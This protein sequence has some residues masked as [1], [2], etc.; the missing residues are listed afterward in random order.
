MFTF[1][2]S[3]SIRVFIAAAC[4][5]SLTAACSSSSSSEDFEIVE[6]L[7]QQVEELQQQLE[8][9][10]ES[11]VESTMSTTTA[12]ATTTTTPATTTTAP[13][14]TTTTTAPPT[15]TTAAPVESIL[16]CE[17]NIMP[18][19]VPSLCGF[20]R[21][22][23]YQDSLLGLIEILGAPSQIGWFSPTCR[24]GYEPETLEGSVRWGN[25][26]V[27]YL[28]EPDLD[29]DW[30]V[31]QEPYLA[32]WTINFMSLPSWMEEKLITP[33]MISLPGGA[34]VEGSI[35]SLAEAFSF[36]LADANEAPYQTGELDAEEYW[37]DVGEYLEE[38][39][40]PEGFDGPQFG[41]QTGFVLH[42]HAHY[43]DVTR[44]IGV[45][46]LPYCH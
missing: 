12:P 8:L 44:A 15:T 14:A 26:R 23:S 2:E 9:A 29:F 40:Y 46:W 13:P 31:Y 22:D 28:Q 33:D 11:P 32:N 24:G 25:L 27:S 36:D 34:D 10:A 7:S 43:G 30:T 37:I 4:L 6:A 17:I 41:I 5:A 45:P 39:D 1:K 16:G 19:T 20:H 42:Q 21:G 3:F 18:G 35:E 38:E